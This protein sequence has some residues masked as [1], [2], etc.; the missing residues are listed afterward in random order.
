MV[1]ENTLLS[2]FKIALIIC[3][4]FATLFV[5]ISVILFFVFDIRTIFNIRTGRAKKRTIDEMSKINS[6]TGRL[7]IDGK[8]VTSRLD[9]KDKKRG[10]RGESAKL[11]KQSQTVSASTENNVTFVN[12]GGAQ[13]D[14]LKYQDDMQTS[15]LNKTGDFQNKPASIKSAHLS[16]AQIK[17][18]GFSI[19]KKVI[20]VHTD[21][22]IS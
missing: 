5:T 21:E 7:R 18:I 15:K 2:F 16:D 17:E 12:D 10:E 8:T 9:Q 3:I 14:V 13:T 1:D 4:S 22:T 19:V 6:S 11:K 20:L